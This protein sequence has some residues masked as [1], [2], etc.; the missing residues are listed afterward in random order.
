M[1][2]MGVQK[3]YKPSPTPILYVGHATNVL[4]RVPLMPLFLLGNSSFASPASTGAPGFHMGWQIQPTSLAGRDAMSRRSTN[5]CGS[6]G[7]ANRVLGACRWL[8]VRPEELRIT[9]A[10][11]RIKDGSKRAVATRG[12][13]RSKAPKAAGAPCGLE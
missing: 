8:R 9:V 6:L 11:L 10:E 1:E 7:W 13:R 12:R 5:G 4:G 2:A 3:L